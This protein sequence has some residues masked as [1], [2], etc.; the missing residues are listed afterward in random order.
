[1]TETTTETPQ[2]GQFGVWRHAGGLAPEVGAAIESAG[3]GAI[4]IGGSPPA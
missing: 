2:L 4:W 3:Y 1:M